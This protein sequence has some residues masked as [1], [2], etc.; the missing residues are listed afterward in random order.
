MDEAE[1]EFFCDESN[2]KQNEDQIRKPK[3]K[4]PGGLL[5]FVERLKMFIPNTVRIVNEPRYPYVFVPLINNG[6]DIEKRKLEEQVLVIIHE[7]YKNCDLKVT[8]VDV[9]KRNS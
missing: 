6:C 3:V 7:S 1:V 5:S 8:R 9:P 4:N 2:G